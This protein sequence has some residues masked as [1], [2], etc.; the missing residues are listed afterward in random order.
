MLIST[1]FTHCSLSEY[2]SNA[3][4]SQVLYNMGPKDAYG[5]IQNTETGFDF[6]VETEELSQY[7]PYR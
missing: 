6:D 5:C 2:H 4:L 1:D 7:S 3:R